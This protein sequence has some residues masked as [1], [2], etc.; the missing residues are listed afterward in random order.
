MLLST[1]KAFTWVEYLSFPNE[2]IIILFHK[3]WKGTELPNTRDMHFCFLYRSERTWTTTS[4]VKLFSLFQLTKSMNSHGCFHYINMQ[5]NKFYPTLSNPLQLHPNPI[6]NPLWIAFVSAW[7][8][9]LSPHC[10]YTSKFH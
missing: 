8:Q 9:I 3:S 4:V 5:P 7:G 1:K 6:Y 2:L 10:C